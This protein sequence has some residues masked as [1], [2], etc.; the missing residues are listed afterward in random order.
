MIKAQMVYLLGN[1]GVG[2]HVLAEALLK[3]NFYTA[4]MSYNAGITNLGKRFLRTIFTFEYF[5]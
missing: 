2:S 4:K 1:E 5:P 3:A